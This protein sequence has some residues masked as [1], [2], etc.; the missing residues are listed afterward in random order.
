MF[1]ACFQEQRTGHPSCLL[2]NY[3]MILFDIFLKKTLII[4]EINRIPV[5]S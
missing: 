3:P 4:R 2:K 5:L 1:P